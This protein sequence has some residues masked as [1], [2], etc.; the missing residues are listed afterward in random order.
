MPLFLILLIYNILLPIIVILALPAWVLKM[1]KRG[2]YG[3]GLMQR[4]S[5][6]DTA[7]EDE[8]KNVVY[9]HAV[10]VGEVLIALKLIDKWLLLHP[11]EKFVLAAT[12]ATGHEVA[13]KRLGEGP[14]ANLR[15]VYSPL[16]FGFMV[17]SVF[18]RF[19]P[20]QIILVESEVW[21][22]F[23]RIAQK[24]KIPVS[25]V[26]ARLSE[27]S[28][29]RFRRF[30]ILVQPIFAMLDRVC[31]QN[32]GDA[33]RFASL[34][35]AAERIHCVGSIKFDPSGG[36]LPKKREEFQELID[37]FGHRRKI[38]L[39][40]STHYGEEKFI[41]EAFLKSGAAENNLLMVVPRHSERRNEVVGDMEFLGFEAILK[42]D[43]HPPSSERPPCF[44]V[45][46][47]GE[48]RDWTAHADLAVIGKSFLG[49]GGQNPVEAI[50]AGV[51]VLCGENMGNF[52]PLV[53]QLKQAG[54]L[55]SVSSLTELA[56]ELFNM[57]NKNQNTSVVSENAQKTVT[58]HEGAVVKT[59]ELLY[60]KSKK[61]EHE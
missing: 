11:E 44:I 20:K 4:L 7:P 47:T 5:L 35:I 24:K 31:A 19:Q 48:L 51:P 34:G 53:E 22:N 17:R 3:T 37:V 9:V 29:A 42:T 49:K 55:V 56:T 40:V 10:S 41:G 1:W 8:P 16:D 27:R 57:L 12:T 39:A 32:T 33:R 21:P 58:N 46:T 6:Y 13:R 36:A 28:E 15:V 23:V 26:N 50:M 43:F 30:K 59:I 14:G 60:L 18:R 2:G 25:I 52:E 61:T 45:D 38:V 54:G